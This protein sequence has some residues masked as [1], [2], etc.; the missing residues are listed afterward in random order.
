MGYDSGN[1]QRVKDAYTAKRKQAEQVAEERKMQ[2]HA[3]SPAIAEI[4]RRLSG[5]GLLLFRIASQ[6]GEDLPKKIEEARKENQA[7]LEEKHALLAALGLPADYT[8]IHYECTLCSDTGYLPST[9]MCECMKRALSV[10][11]FRASGLGSLVER[12]S[13]D[14]F[15]LDRFEE[16]ERPLMKHNLDFLRKYANTFRTGAKSLIL[17][18]G[19]GLGKTHLSTS[20]ARVVIERGYSVIYDTAHNIVFDFNYDQFK[21]KPEEE[22]RSEKYL[23]CDLLLLDDLGTEVQTKHTASYLYNLINTRMNRGKTTVV[24]TNLTPNE[25]LERYG[26]R[27]SSRLFG[28]YEILLFRGKDIR[29][30]NNI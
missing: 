10:E 11:G 1:F 19:T 23:D 6:G 24:S 28:E 17:I 18:G 7:L 15:S 3:L 21:S 26:D 9:K 14:N 13:F 20:L 30:K 27:L 8:E 25:V 12:Q 2:V 4:D 16:E 29:L 22:L 5:T